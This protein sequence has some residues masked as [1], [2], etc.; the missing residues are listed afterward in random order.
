MVANQPREISQ[1]D[2]SH[3]SHTTRMPPKRKDA[4][5][6]TP[7]STTTSSRSSPPVNKLK[8]SPLRFISRIIR[9]SICLL[10]LYALYKRYNPS[11]TSPS[12]SLAHLREE[13][14]RVTYEEIE[15]DEYKRDR[16]LDAFKVRSSNGQ[17]R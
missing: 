3:C 7:P 6:P 12:S 5:Q 14:G 2:T 4:T 16:I 17:R 8:F 10:A 9:T 15:L 11:N 13:Q 1:L